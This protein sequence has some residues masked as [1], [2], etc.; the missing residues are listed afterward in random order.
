[1][2][3]KRRRFGY[4]RKLPSGRYQ[5]SFIGPSGLRQSAPTTFK[6]RTDADRWLTA[7]ETDIARGAW[8]DEDLGRES[9]GNYARAWLRD[10]P[11]DGATV[12]GD[13]RAEPA[14]A[15]GSAGRRAA[16][17]ADSGGGPGVVCVGAC[18]GV[19]A[20]PRSCSPTGSCAR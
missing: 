17:G 14:A 6:T 5:A 18:G 10:H 2:A 7:A 11:E 19:A 16:E 12:P 13:L 8:L 20:G 4:V 3:G 9:F 15:P 1:M